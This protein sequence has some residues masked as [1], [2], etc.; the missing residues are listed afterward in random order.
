MEKN[1]ILKCEEKDGTIVCSIKDK[2]LLIVTVSEGDHPEDYWSCDYVC[3]KNKIQEIISKLKKE[4]FWS[5]FKDRP[6]HTILK[7]FG[8][9]EI[10][11]K[12]N[13]HIHKPDFGELKID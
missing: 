6:P 5:I 2:N 3:P 1:S 11:L 9:K 10:L 7:N 12:S 4:E 13:K 8:C